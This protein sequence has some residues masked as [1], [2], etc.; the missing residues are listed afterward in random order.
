MKTSPRIWPSIFIGLSPLVAL[1]ASVVTLI[2]SVILFLLLIFL[3]G[4]SSFLY[5][6]RKDL[7]T[8]TGNS[9]SADSHIE[10]FAVRGFFFLDG[11]DFYYE[12][13][14]TPGD[15]ERLVRLFLPGGQ[16]EA[17]NGNADEFVPAAW[18]NGSQSIQRYCLHRPD[19]S[20]V[21]L[22]ALDSQSDKAWLVI[23]NF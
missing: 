11:P 18:R 16:A 20:E 13:S 10:H 9:I 8:Y 12:L 17:L 5:D 14:L 3:L 4:N 23:E 2:V 1:I 22:L 7:D 21:L 19:K 15:R 6:A